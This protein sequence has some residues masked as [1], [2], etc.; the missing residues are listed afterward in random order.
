VTEINL[1]KYATTEQGEQIYL[2]FCNFNEAIL[3]ITKELSIPLTIFEDI[4]HRGIKKLVFV[5]TNPV[6]EL[7]NARWEF[8][9]EEVDAIKNE[10]RVGQEIQYYFSVK[11]K[12]LTKEKA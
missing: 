1:G 3:W 11:S 4:K 10:K 12:L 7:A 9:T 6:G 8:L 5:N 2:K